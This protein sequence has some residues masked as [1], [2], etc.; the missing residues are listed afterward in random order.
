MKFCSAFC[1]AVLAVSFSVSSWAGDEAPQPTLYERLGGAEGVELIVDGILERHLQN[2]TLAPY[3]AHLDHEWFSDT[4]VKFF[5]RIDRRVGEIGR[6]TI[7]N[8]LLQSQQEEPKVLLSME[9][10]MK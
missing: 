9:R 8:Y 10:M 1:A 3:F 6:K 2:E 4:I 7:L 5:T